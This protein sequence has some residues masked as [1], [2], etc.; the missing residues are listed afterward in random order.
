M[1]VFVSDDFDVKKIIKAA[2]E[3][4]T[5]N[6]CDLSEMDA[7]Q[8]KL[9]DTIYKKRYLLVLDD[10]WN[11]DQDEWDRLRPLFG[12]GDDGSK[13]V[14]TTR[15][16]KV[17]FIMDTPDFAYYLKGLPEDDCWTLF[18]R[19]AF[20]RGEEEKHPHLLPI[21]KQII[22]K[23][24]GLPLAAKTLGSLMRFKREES[25]WLFVQN[26]NL[27][28]LDVCQSGIVPALILSY[29]HLPSHLKHCFALCSIFPKNYEIQKEKLIHIWMAEGFIISGG[30][31]KPLE[32]IG[33]EYFNELLWMSFF[34]DVKQCDDGSITGYKIHDLIYDLA[35]YITR[36]DHVILE[37]D[38]PQSDLAQIRHLSI[39]RDHR[40][41]L[42]PEALDRANHL[43]TL[44]VV[45]G[46]GFGGNPADMFSHFIYLRVL[47]LSGCDIKLPKSIG[48]L[49]C[50]KY[51]DLS[52]THIEQLPSTF[53]GLCSLLILN[54]FGCYNL[55][56]LPVVIKMT[57]L[58]HLNIS[59]CEK[60]NDMPRG[61]EKLV[62]LQTLPIFVVRSSFTDL[63]LQTKRSNLSRLGNLNLR[64]ELKIK[65]LERVEN[66]DEAKKANLMNKEY[67]KSLGLCW[68][69]DDTSLLPNPALEASTARFL[70]RKHQTPG[71]SQTNRC[72]MD[73]DLG[74][75][76]LADL[77]P[78]Q[79]LQ[80]LFV[81]GFP[82]LS[83]PHWILPKLTMVVLINCRG[84]LHLPTLG[85]LPLLET[86]RMEGMAEVTSIG[87]EFY[88]ENTPLI[89]P[90]L[91]ELTIG[92]FP[93]LQE[94]SSTDGRETF[95]KLSKLT[96]RKCPNL[97]VMPSVLSLQHLE[98]H[99]CNPR[100]IRSLENLTL[101]SDLVIKGFT[102]LLSLPGILLRNNCLLRSLKIISCPKL[103]S[104]PSELENLTSLK[105]L[106]IRWCEE[107]S[108][109][110]LGFQNLTALESLE[111][112][113]CHSLISLPQEGIGGL[114]S[115]RTLSIENC[116]NLASI[117]MKF[118]DF[119]AL[120][121][122]TIMY[123]P[124]LAALP[125]DLQYL[126]AIRSLTILECPE[127]AVL[128]EGLQHATTLQTLEI[129]SCPSVTALPEWLEKISSLRSLAISDCQNLKTL[130]IALRRLSG[131]R[132][133]SIQD[134]PDLE[135]R[136]QQDG[137]ADW[138]KITHVSY[139]YIFSS[140]SRQSSGAASSST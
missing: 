128:P 77:Q 102:E 49:H 130:P 74:V 120:E 60:L 82:G 105:S 76:V 22:K 126:S 72:E 40:S 61:I 14:V 48:K 87:K 56:S 123:C 118:Q 115:L 11:E 28:E 81:V 13:I 121:H 23:C 45:S 62:H 111:I 89:F 53:S 44:L 69:N 113:D 116:S 66:G 20:H 17:A 137:G 131:L 50:L 94:W 73:A 18:K 101:L 36:N 39:V 138:W 42:I 38:L 106:T 99:D 135:R 133:L 12:G 57:E 63:T 110:P 2:I 41:S 109:L 129:R 64:G 37:N 25:E 71:P 90:S 132:H 85:H 55:K 6:G 75:E 124:S 8:S 122:L 7:L 70:E 43:R 51:L 119:T 86:L 33:D 29:L 9:W 16:K 68:G 10:V 134:C 65:H 52:N 93:V 84:C 35:Q 4:A 127:L 26:S 32:K 136:C 67:L 92:D 54:L 34:E 19:R 91:L 58:R 46:G 112:G 100:I 98:L 80:R 97:I 114:S 83:F 5:K 103:H 88:G 125:D 104:L 31:S 59:G 3:S 107:L 21:G 95:P 47:D 139:R 30:R 117:S 27:W 24:G 15:S 78:H 79:N 1:W 108:S 140:E 96:V